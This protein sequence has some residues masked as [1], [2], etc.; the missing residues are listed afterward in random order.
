MTQEE[1]RQLDANELCKMLEENYQ[2]AKPNSDCS[3]EI[4]ALSAIIN[5]RATALELLESF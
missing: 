1:R 2:H 5:A 4:W 3:L